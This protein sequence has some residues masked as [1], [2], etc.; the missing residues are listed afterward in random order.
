MELND[1]NQIDRQLVEKALQNDAEAFDQLFR[2]H[3]KEL[4][5]YCMQWTGNN[6]SDAGDILQETLI[7]VYLH[8]DKY[9]PDYTF[10]QWIHT[11]ARNS[12]I[13]HTRKRKEGHLSI[14]SQD[15]AGPRLNPP[16]NTANPEERMMQDQTGK[17]LDRALDRMSPR[18]K[19][20]ITMRFIQEYSYE[21]IAEKLDMPLGTVK[22]Q[23]HRAREQFYRIISDNDNIL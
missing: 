22:T 9:N 16:A 2:R 13:D 23:I 21:E 5:R 1:R 3:K 6:L 8:L 15:W 19:T 11:I 12:F 17:E 10:S 20:M 7:K 4:H 18:Y 14:D